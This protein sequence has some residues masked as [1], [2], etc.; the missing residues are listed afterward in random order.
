MPDKKNILV[1]PLDW[2]LGH[3]TRCVPIIQKL[4]NSG[5]NVIIGADGRP[6]ALLKKEF[7]TLQF[8][9]FPGYKINYPANGSMTI[10]MLFL[11]PRILIGIKKEHKLVEEIIKE[12][13]IDAL[14]SDNRY[15]LWSKSIKCIFITHQISIQTPNWLKL[16]KKRIFKLNKHYIDRFTECWIPDFKKGLNL[17]GRLTDNYSLF[18]NIFFIGPLSRFK[19]NNIVK[20]EANIYDILFII[21]GPEPQRTIF[22]DIVL[23]QAIINNSLKII[24][25]RGITESD[26]VKQVSENITMINNLGTNEL[27]DMILSSSLII[28]RPGYSSI[29]DMVTLSKNAIFVPTPGQTEQIYLAYHLKKKSAFYYVNQINFNISFAIENSKYYQGMVNKI[30]ADPLEERINL[31]LR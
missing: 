16:F 7:P 10:K 13:D 23:E 25:V 29:M 6:L 15:G 21:S 1:C 26:E 20:S 22:E 14:I 3:A 17:S 28:C 31:L 9:N 5:A 8:I 24:I 2:G 4:T 30:T 19:N 11:S 12:Y 18:N 27:M